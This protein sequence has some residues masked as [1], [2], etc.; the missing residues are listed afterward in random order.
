MKRILAL[1]LALIMLLTLAA[2]GKDEESTPTGESTGATTNTTESTNDPTD[3]TQ[4]STQ[5]TTE[6]TTGG[7]TTETTEPPTTTPPTTTPPTTTPPTTT[8]PT[9][10][11]PTTTPPTTTPPATEAPHTHSYSS[12]VTTAA[13]CGK[14]GVKT[15]TCSCGDSYTEKIA[16]TGQHSWGSW[17]TETVALVNRTGT[18]K[19]TCST[20]SAAETRENTENVLE[21]SFYDPGLGQLFYW[22]FNYD[23]SLRVYSL[24]EYAPY[25]YDKFAYKENSTDTIYDTLAKSFVLDD[26]FKDKIRAEG[27]A[28]P[29]YYGYNEANDT[30]TF[31][32]NNMGSMGNAE[33]VGYIHNGGNQ[34]TVYYSFAE[35]GSDTEQIY[36]VVLEFKRTDRFDMMDWE[37]NGEE[38]K[39]LSFEKVS[40]VPSDLTK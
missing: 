32:G 12:K 22:G 29:Y 23:G 38:N 33:P 2:C 26:S 27:K 14:D 5:G 7:D 13:T 34:Y 15:F 25:R 35:N 6:S 10:T 36:K 4:D 16:A 39:Y 1:L 17:S 20:C 40:S 19:R 28:N 11:P 21:N 31:E 8:P 9:T 30:F 24:L 3:G 37:L 18:D